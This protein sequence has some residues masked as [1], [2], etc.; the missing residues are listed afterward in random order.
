MYITQ[1]IKQE[2]YALECEV[3]FFVMP[4]PREKFTRLMA[5]MEE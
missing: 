5:H 1:I 4:S 2:K 3:L